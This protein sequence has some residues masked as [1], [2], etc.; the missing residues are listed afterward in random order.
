GIQKIDQPCSA[1]L[2]LLTATKISE[3]VV[4]FD[5]AAATQKRCDVGSNCTCGSNA[6]LASGSPLKKDASV[7]L[8]KTVPPLP[9][10]LNAPFI[11]TITWCGPVASPPSGGIQPV[12]PEPL[13]FVPITMSPGMPPGR[14]PAGGR[15]FSDLG[16]ATPAAWLAPTPGAACHGTPRDE[17]DGTTS[18]CVRGRK[19]CNPAAEL[20]PGPLRAR[21]TCHPPEPAAGGAIFPSADLIGG[22]DPAAAPE[23]A[24]CLCGAG[25]APAGAAPASTAAVSIPAASIPAVPAATRGRAAA[26]A[27]AAS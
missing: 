12:Y 9:K 6:V 8:L 14:A 21:A 25:A 2:S 18:L 23:A 20:R 16:G 22:S 13:K 3:L 4:P 19:T 11:A 1:S 5:A 10:T 17:P 7:W 15:T 24:A 27:Q 26:A